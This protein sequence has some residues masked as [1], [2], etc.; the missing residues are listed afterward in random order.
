MKINILCLYYD[1]M[2]LYGDTGNLKVIEHHLSKLNISYNIDYLSIDDRIDF[3]K[4]DLILIGSGTEN[5]RFICLNH[6][7]KYKKDIDKAISNNKFF[8]ITGNAVAMF[9]KSIYDKKAL[10]L[11][12]LSVSESPIRI[13]KEVVIPYENTSIYGMINTSDIIT[14][15]DNYLFNET[16]VLR[17]NFY[18]SYVIGPI[19]A[20]NPDFLKTF[21][22]KLIYS[23]DKD[24]DVSLDL[25]LD[26]KAYDEFIEFKKTKV[27]NSKKA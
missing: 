22:E 8:L 6:L 12:N 10:G 27:F 1:L 19:L 17:N 18:G 26:K 15:N 21:I 23:K 4:Y 14:N 5:N 7:L 3:S 25:S 2:N 9:G 16:G 11:I 20:K 24:F 13:S